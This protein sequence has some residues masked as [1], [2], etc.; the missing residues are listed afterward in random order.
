MDS[1][2]CLPQVERAVCPIVWLHLAF[3]CHLDSGVTD[4]G[5]G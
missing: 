5:L 3:T 2:V 1:N 4:V